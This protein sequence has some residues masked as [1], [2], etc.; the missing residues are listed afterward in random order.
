MSTTK[1]ET[2]NLSKIAIANKDKT[3]YVEMANSYVTGNTDPK[4]KSLN[5][6]ETKLGSQPV[7]AD[8]LNEMQLFVP[9][10]LMR[11]GLPGHKNFPADYLKKKKAIGDPNIEGFFVSGFSISKNGLINIIGGCKNEDGQ[12]T[13]MTAPITSLD[14]DTSKYQ[15]VKELNVLVENCFE[16]ATDYF[17]HGKFG[18]GAQNTLDLKEPAATA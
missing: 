9:H 7:H 4:K 14:I 6:E 15:Y 18:E 13:S 17:R 10:L 5:T 16:H 1:K 2:M 3:L 11:C 12:V 8:F